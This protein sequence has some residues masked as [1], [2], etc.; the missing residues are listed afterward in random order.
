MIQVVISL[1]GVIGTLSSIMFAY[2]AFRRN[3]CKDVTTEAKREGTL[4]SDI[5]YM[6][7]STDRMEGKLDKVEANYQ[8]LLTRVIKVEEAYNSLNQRLQEH[9]TQE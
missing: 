6:K 1:I 8:L 4:L 2:L 9:I 5:G 3:S 7:S